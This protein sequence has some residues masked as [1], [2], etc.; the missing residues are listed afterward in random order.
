VDRRPRHGPALG[1]RRPL[2]PRVDRPPRDR[3][4]DGYVEYERRNPETG[5][6]NQ[7]WK[8]PWDSIQHADGRL[9]KSPRATCEIQGYVYDAKLRCARL[10]RTVWSDSELAARLEARFNRDFWIDDRSFFPGARRRQAPRRRPDLE[11]R[12][13]PVE[14]HREPDKGEACVRDLMGERLYS[15]WGIRTMAEGDAAY[16]PIGYHVGT[17]WPH[18]NSLIA[19]G[20][21]RYGYRKEAAQV[22]PAI[23][24]AAHFFRGRL[25]E[26]FA[27]YPRG[28][29]GCPV[30]YPTACSPQAWSTGAPCS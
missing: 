23:L 18:D 26:A 13:S 24:E 28:M 19:W 1:V 6:E 27:G 7:C 9:A 5:L 25:P 22:A 16:N 21:R 11:H 10:A 4:G 8:E 20:L 30:E 2:R 15:G 12:P 3:D 29:T 17:I 14:R